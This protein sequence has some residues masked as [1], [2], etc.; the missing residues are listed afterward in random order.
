MLTALHQNIFVSYF[1]TLQADLRL[2]Q[3][4]ISTFDTVFQRHATLS[5]LYV[6]TNR[7]CVFDAILVPSEA[8]ANEPISFIE[9]SITNAPN[10]K[11]RLPKASPIMNFVHKTLNS[12][13][14]VRLV[15]IFSG[16][17][18]ELTDSHKS[19][20][21]ANPLLHSTVIVCKEGCQKLGVKYSISSKKQRVAKGSGAL[22]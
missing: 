22:P 1:L 8:L 7:L 4:F 2:N 13:E 18:S 17:T 12:L 20:Q 5:I 16:A 11:N 15:I 10:T 3:Q 6:P 21:T 14:N 9:C 19:T